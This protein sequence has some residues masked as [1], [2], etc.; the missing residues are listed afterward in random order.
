MAAF[1]IMKCIL[2][3]NNSKNF[4]ISHNIC[5]ICINYMFFYICF[6]MFLCI[7]QYSYEI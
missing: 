2:K 4:E 3:D 1:M 6:Y 5:E 7:Y